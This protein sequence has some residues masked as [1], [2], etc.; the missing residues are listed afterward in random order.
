MATLTALTEAATRHMPAGPYRDFTIWVCSPKNPRQRE[1]LQAAG[2]LQ[3]INMSDTLL[4]GHLDDDRWPA[5]LR[6]TSLMNAY[7]ILE[8]I[9]DDLAI[10]LGNADLDERG[11]LRRGLV[12]TVNRAM[13][14]ILTPG[15]HQ[16]AVLLLAGPARAAAKQT[17]GFEHSSN[18]GIRSYAAE[19]ALSLAAQGKKVPPLEEIEF[20]L[21]PAL[22][23]NVETCRELADKMDGTATASLLR[24]GLIDRYRAVDRTLFAQHLSRLELASLGAQ[25]ILIAPTLAFV[26]G[27]LMERIRPVDGYAEIIANGWINDVL[28]DAALMIRLLNDVGTRLLRMPPVQQAAALHAITGRDGDRGLE[29]LHDHGH[30]PVFT[31]LHKDLIN[32]ESNV[33][34]WHARR[35]KGPKEA[36]LA[37]AESLAYFANLY[38]Q[39]SARLA[40]GLAALDERLGDRRASSVIERLVRFHEHMYSHPHMEPAGEFAHEPAKVLPYH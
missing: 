1:F 22:V 14:E 6:Y 29:L 4:L 13:I 26:L 28:S 32:G 9:S 34:L 30:D 27:A 12:S 33:A 11:R 8:V 31:R 15:R 17:S 35:A 39:H 16:P 18:R 24:E 19:F 7:Q 10:G 21:W 25:T 37:L 20:G 40:A 2:I 3:L 5:M 38:T 36:W 23:A